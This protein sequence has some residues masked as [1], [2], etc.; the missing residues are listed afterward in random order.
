MGC[1]GSGCLVGSMQVRVSR[2]LQWSH[3][4]HWRGAGPVPCAGGLGPR[5]P[6]HRLP[7][8]VVGGYLPKQKTAPCH[9]PDPSPT[10]RVTP[11]PVLIQRPALTEDL[12]LV[13]CRSTSAS[14]CA[15]CRTEV[16]TEG[17]GRHQ[18]RPAPRHS[19]HCYCQTTRRWAYCACAG[20][21]VQ[22]RA[23]LGR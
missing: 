8:P 20:C 14:C 4:S 15:L 12:R 19:A 3:F 6:R 9:I 10:I 1:R 18:S 22:L 23:G 17:R 11:H 5:R 21:R 2:E 16:S 13:W 7:S